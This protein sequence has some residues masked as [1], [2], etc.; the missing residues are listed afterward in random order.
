MTVL[1]TLTWP[2]IFA[3][4]LLG[5]AH[6]V[7]MCGG[8]ALT[9]GSAATSGRSNLARQLIYSAGRLSTYGLAGGIAAGLGARFSKA[10]PAVEYGQAILALLAGALLLAEGLKAIGWWPARLRRAT[11]SCPWR[12]GFSTLLNSN[13]Q[14]PIFVAG[15]V[16][17][18]LPCGLVY[19]FL[20][21]AAQ[22]GSV[23]RGS[24]TM[25]AFGSGTVP[26][27]VAFGLTPIV[28][29][30]T[31]RRRLFRVAAWCLVLTGVLTLTR[32]ITL[33]ESLRHATPATCPFCESREAQ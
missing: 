8:F 24:A 32:G 33:A 15:L 26:L 29:N 6:C 21:L 19:A 11:H 13:R 27:M 18:W 23:W 2:M 5:S 22:T 20:S 30:L 17:G 9:V 7:G 3:G 28:A 25:L 14:L 16:T 12:N 4:G 10:L 31:F 1:D